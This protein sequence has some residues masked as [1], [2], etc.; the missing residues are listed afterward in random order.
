[1][2]VVSNTSPLNY[3]ILIGQEMLLERLFGG[4][5]VPPAVLEELSAPQT[6]QVVRALVAKAPSWRAVR[7]PAVVLDLPVDHG[8]RHAISLAVEVQA[9]LLLIDDLAGRRAAKAAGVSILG[10]L[11]FLH[12]A[13]ERGW[14]DFADAIAKLQRTNFGLSDELL[15]R[16]T[17]RQPR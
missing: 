4:I 9:D 1:M 8:E 15:R 7:P 3:L 11:G 6:P 5:T 17:V 12:T 16:F 2:I 13:A 14:L 10:T